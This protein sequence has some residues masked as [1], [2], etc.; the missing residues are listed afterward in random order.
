MLSPDLDVGTPVDRSSEASET[1]PKGK[2][3]LTIEYQV[4]GELT[5]AFRLWDVE[6][7]VQ[8]HSVL[9]GTRVYA[10]EATKGITIQ[11]LTWVLKVSAPWRLREVIRK[12][13]LEKS[14]LTIDDY[15][16]ARKTPEYIWKRP[17][18]AGEPRPKKVK[19]I[20]AWFPRPRDAPS[21]TR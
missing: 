7:D 11:E 8:V 3:E 13:A 20:R 2:V 5:A 12:A 10:G 18:L 15:G 17:L 16:G 9:E 4:R 21:G 6:L 1:D 14:Y 19:R